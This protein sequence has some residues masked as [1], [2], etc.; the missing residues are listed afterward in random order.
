[1]EYGINYAK[2]IGQEIEYRTLPD[3]RISLLKI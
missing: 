1:M 2:E 3:K